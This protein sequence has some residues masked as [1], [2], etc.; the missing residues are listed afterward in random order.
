[1]ALGAA[2]SAGPLAK[3]PAQHVPAG[4]TKASV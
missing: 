2:S 3:A 4:V 1:M